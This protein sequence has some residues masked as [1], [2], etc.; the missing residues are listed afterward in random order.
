MNDDVLLL[1][2]AARLA[3]E[4]GAA[5]IAV[6][7]RGY[8]VAEKPDRSPVTDA[9]MV[10][11]RLIIAGLTAATPDIPVIAEESPVIGN[12]A[13]PRVFWLV[14]PL[15][16][17]REFANGL[18]EFVV[19]I[20]LIRGQKVALGAV[21][22]PALHEIFIGIVGQGVWKRS[23]GKDA[24]IHVRDVASGGPVALV[25]RH[26][27][28]DR[29]LPSMLET[30]MVADTVKMGSGLKFCRI[31]E[32]QA[33][34]YIRPGR[35]MEWDTAAPQAI[36]EAAGGAV[37]TMGGEPLLYGKPNWENPSFV[38]TGAQRIGKRLTGAVP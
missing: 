31:A 12:T 9:D 35:T 19:N 8:S 32:G 15:D 1:S 24:P 4:A 26:D 33:D 30:H 20:G 7:A 36:L 13:I 11:Q 27:A 16:G 17:T 34:L 6:R 37:L 2:L 23:A 18:D 3:E 10:S 28:D 21:A 38:C 5:I 14:D 29:R 22:A 25:S